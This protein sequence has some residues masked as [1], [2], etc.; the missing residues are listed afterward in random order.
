MGMRRIV[1]GIVVAIA[2]AGALP[3]APAAAEG[4]TAAAMV[5]NADFPSSF[6][7]ASDGRVFFT[8]KN[9]GRI[10][11]WKDG[12]GKTTFASVANLCTT[13]EQ[14]LLG[15]ALAPGSPDVFVYAVR[16][17]NGACR[18]QVLR[19]APGSTNPT[20]IF[21]EAGATPN[22]VGGR[23]A[24]G[25]DGNL[26]L[27]IGDGQ[28][29][30][31]SQNT[32]SPKGKILRMTTAGAA[33]SGNPIAG[34]RMFA[35][36]LR[37]VFGFDFDSSNGNEVWATEN[38]PACN[39]EIDHIQAGHNYGWGPSQTCTTGTA[40]QNTNADG[41]SP[42]LPEHW[43]ADANGPT[44][45][46]FCAGC[47][48]GA[49][50]D[51]RLLYGSVGTGEIRALTLDSARAA[52]IGD[53]LAYAHPSGVLAVE[54]GPD[55]AIWF[56]D[57]TTIYRLGGSGGGGGG[58]TP[59]ASVGDTSVVEGDSGSS[60]LVFT[61]TLDAASA[62]DVSVKYVTRNGTAGS[63]DYQAV[64]GRLT[65]PAGAQSRTVAVPVQPDNIDEADETLTLVV[66]RPKNVVIADAIGVG[67][68]L[69]DD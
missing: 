68:I 51:G 5:Q 18:E 64:E 10:R 3:P 45:A 48:L 49:D 53:Q 40:P 21:D 54:S 16:N 46:A 15:I 43:W 8:E 30:A 19:V 66:K 62:K 47:G 12:S 56:S 6:T 55:N 31:N 4:V 1:F 36:G 38:G 11:F 7:V 69:D 17:V 26:W 61:V 27:S 41:P 52:V 13:G 23:L 28:E 42:H 67:T 22:H 44:G 65:I 59:S 9:T 35:Y 24:L 58:G 29:P 20:V 57:T 32:A 63:A 60:Q 33:A 14:G 34:N 39:D 2:A 25:P 37:N 50:L